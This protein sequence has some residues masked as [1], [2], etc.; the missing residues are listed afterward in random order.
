MITAQSLFTLH[1]LFDTQAILASKCRRGC[2]SSQRALLKHWL[3]I[4]AQSHFTL[5]L[6]F[7]GQASLGF[8]MP[9]W[10]LTV[11]AALLKHWLLRASWDS[12]ADANGLLLLTDNVHLSERGATIVAGEVSFRCQFF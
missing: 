3:A 11:A 8:N 5:H 12:V 9:T 4:T 10:P 6:A 1:L 2:S 7:V